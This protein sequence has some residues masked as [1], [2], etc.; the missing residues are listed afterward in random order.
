MATLTLSYR[1]D[2]ETVLRFLTDPE[3]V[4]ARSEAFGEREVRVTVDGGTVTATRIV[5]AEVPSFARKLVKPSNQVT[6]IKKWNLATKTATFSVDVRGVPVTIA[7]EIAL[8][9]RAGGG[10]DCTVRFEVTCKIPLIGGTLAK[11]VT[12]MTENGLR[13]EF[14]WNQRGLDELAAKAS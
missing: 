3:R 5:D 11:H 8:A 7:G 14:E 2:P 13:R 6:D 12:G 1:Q 10:A 4:K 9:A